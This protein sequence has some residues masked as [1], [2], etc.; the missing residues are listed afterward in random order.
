MATDYREL[1]RRVSSLEE[2]LKEISSDLHDLVM[3]ARM[4]QGIE[5]HTLE[6][7]LLNTANKITRRVGL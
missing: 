6:S 1:E 2:L 5:P 7:F 3:E 4:A